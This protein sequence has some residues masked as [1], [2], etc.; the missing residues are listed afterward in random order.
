VNGAAALVL[1]GKLPVP[2]QVKTRLA[3]RL[4]DSG[5]AALAEAF[6]RDAAE[7]YAALDGVAPVVAAAPDAAD[8]FWRNTFPA[9]WRIEAQ[10]DGDLGQRLAGAFRREFRRRERVAAVGADHPALP[11]DGLRRFMAERNAIW[12][13]RD[14]GY[15][16]ILLERSARALDLFDGIPWS[17]DRV[18]AET[19]ERARRAGIALTGYPE[20]YDVDEPHDL[21]RL[22]SDLQARDRAAPGFPRHSWEAVGRL[23]PAE[24]A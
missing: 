17:T 15:A 3:R 16:A 8:P 19:V 24:S 21:L 1:F 14:G 23:V 6:L 4:G 5:A 2:G 9:P 11:L 12:P 13:S 7:A 10:G 20:T 22:R 18:L